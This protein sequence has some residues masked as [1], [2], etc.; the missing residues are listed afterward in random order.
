MNNMIKILAI[1]GFVAIQFAN[2]VVSANEAGPC[3]M[4]EGLIYKNKPDLTMFGLEK[5]NLINHVHL[6][7][8]GESTSEIPRLEIIEKIN[9]NKQAVNELLVVNVEH[10]RLNLNGKVIDESIDKY[11]Q[12]LAKVK[13]TWPNYNV[14][15]YSMVPE[16]DYW[17]PQ[18]DFRSKRY[19]EW[20]ERNNETSAVLDFADTI[21]PSLYTFYR[22][23]KGWVEY[24]KAQIDEARRIAPG[25]PVYAFLW[26][27][28]HQ[29]NKFSGLDY[30]KGD[31]WRKQL[32][33]ACNYADG[34]VIWGG[35]D[36]DNKTHFQ[37]TGEWDWWKETI[38]FVEDHQPNLKVTK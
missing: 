30:I 37:W 14:G 25:K 35:W 24:A 3:K 32:E 19:L 22:D 23:Q 29:S 26:P 10:W 2:A 1:V 31:Y 34:F 17:T 6:W 36:I 9:L 8:K 11:R 15:L 18:G 4:Y 12:L 21:Y 7:G 38:S 28:Y 20:Q 27:Q 5:I 13:K 16:R 33:L